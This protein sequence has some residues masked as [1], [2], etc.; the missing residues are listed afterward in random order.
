MTLDLS[1]SAGEHT[2][3][4]ES[5]MKTIPHAQKTYLW[6]KFRQGCLRQ[7]AKVDCLL[8]V[9]QGVEWDVKAVLT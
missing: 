7:R 9:H 1:T 6:R 4:E 8:A 3:M 2:A 5:E